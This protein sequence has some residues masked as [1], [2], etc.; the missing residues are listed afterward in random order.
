MLLRRYADIQKCTRGRT[1]N[2]IFFSLFEST[3]L[4]VFKFFFVVEN[5]S[6]RP[7]YTRFTPEVQNGEIL[8][9]LWQIV[10]P[11]KNEYGLIYLP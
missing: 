8:Y 7:K 9:L 6:D 10:F 3:V 1:G 11:Y 2:L 4:Y 5:R